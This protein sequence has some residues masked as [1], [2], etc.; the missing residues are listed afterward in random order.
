MRALG[1]IGRVVGTVLGVAIVKPVSAVAGFIFRSVLV[2]LYRFYFVAK[3]SVIAIFAPAKNKIIFPLQNRGT[4]HF[5]LIVIAVAVLVN[6]LVIKD[7]QASEFGQQSLLGVLT[8]DQTYAPITESGISTVSG[9]AEF[10]RR[11]G[12]LTTSDASQPAETGAGAVTSESSAALVQPTLAD[13]SGSQAPRG[14]AEYYTVQGGDTIS[15]IAEKFG[16]STNTILWEN[17]LGPRDLIKPGGKLTILPTSGVSHQ[18]KSG[19]TIDKIAQRYGVTSD[20]IIDYNKLAAADDIELSQILIV[21]GGQAPEEAAPAVPRSRQPSSTFAILNVPAPSRVASSARLLWPTPSR[22]INQ[23]YKWRHTGID[24]DGD[25][26]SP[27]YAADDG[28]VEFAA[29]DRSGY[30]LH[31]IVNHGGGIKTLYG[32]ESK[33]FVKVGDSVK[34]GQ[35]IGIMGCTGRCTGTHLHFEVRVNGGFQNPLDWL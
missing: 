17:R 31:I 30:G 21:P 29:S 26:S 18:V 19:D 13:T 4:I 25:Y 28:R 34:R 14:T 32:H 7:T 3:R 24:F 20:T 2:P 33:L 5:A 12:A 23:Y 10:S 11:A 16:I 35:T 27:I 1:A 15:T 9:V 22:R 8:S 6:N